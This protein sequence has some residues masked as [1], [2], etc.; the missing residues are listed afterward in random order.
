MD[1]GP[2]FSKKMR[3]INSF[4]LFLFRVNSWGC[5]LGLFFI[6]IV[7]K[8]VAQEPVEAYLI[9]QVPTSDLSKRI[10][11]ETQ[12]KPPLSSTTSNISQRIMKDAPRQMTVG[13]RWEQFEAEFGI[14]QR[15]SSFVKG[16]IESA[17]YNVDKTLFA[18][19][20]LVDNIENILRFEYELQEL[21]APLQNEQEFKRKQ[22]N[23]LLRTLESGSIKSDV[24]LNVF[25]G[26]AFVGVRL[27]LPIGD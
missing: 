9:V 16:N 17:K 7:E 14:Q 3:D 1:K 15:N 24:K 25:S 19:Q 12:E 4:Y 27:V 5:I 8:P 23:F 21:S 20:E 11:R 18:M 26:D 13:E 2:Q 10:N 22:S 6:L